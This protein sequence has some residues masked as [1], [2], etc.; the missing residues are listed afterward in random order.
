MFEKIYSDVSNELLRNN[1]TDIN[2]VVSVY[3]NKIVD[4]VANYFPTYEHNLGGT[5]Q[6]IEVIARQVGNKAEMERYLDENVPKWRNYLNDN[7]FLNAVAVSMA[8]RYFNEYNKNTS[9]LNDYNINDAVL[10]TI[11]RNVN[12]FGLRINGEK[13]FI[14][15]VNKILTGYLLEDKKMFTSKVYHDGKSSYQYVMSK[16]KG[17]ILDELNRNGGKI[18]SSL[19]QEKL[20]STI[21]NSYSRKLASSLYS[22]EKNSEEWIYNNLLEKIKKANLND[23]QKSYLTERLNAGYYNDLIDWNIVSSDEM[24]DMLNKSKKGPTM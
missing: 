6:I 19:P 22:K 9:I 1:I 11:N 4:M 18:R 2:I 16:S 23:K 14:N 17:E 20:V 7:Q 24:E 15:V 5:Q 21:I 12:D 8:E 10:D 3:R 13:E